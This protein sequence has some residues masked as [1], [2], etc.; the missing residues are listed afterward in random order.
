MTEKETTEIIDWFSDKTLKV[1]CIC[2][3]R[4]EYVCP[5]GD[6]MKIKPVMLGD[7]LKRM[8]DEQA[9]EH[10]DQVIAL[11]NDCDLS[12]SLNQ[13]VSDSVWD[14]DDPEAE[15]K[16]KPAKELFELLKTIKR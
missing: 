4:G 7:V 16:Y 11:W 13:I 8:Q 15:I 6:I 9:W 12:K 3:A 5:R 1:G 10:N 14:E 2:C